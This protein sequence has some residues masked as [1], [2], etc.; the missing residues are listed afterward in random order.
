MATSFLPA[1]VLRSSG[2]CPCTSALGLFT[3]KYSALRSKESPLSNATVRTLR[4]LCNRNSVGQGGATPS[5]IFQFPHKQTIEGEWPLGITIP[6][7]AMSDPHPTGQ[8]VDR[9][10][11]R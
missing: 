8:P 4:S 5:I 7:R 3:R 1:T 2:E 11:N 10:E 9:H 6:G